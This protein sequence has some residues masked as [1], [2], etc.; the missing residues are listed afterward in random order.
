[1]PPGTT[2]IEKRTIAS[3][4]PTWEASACTQ[5]RECFHWLCAHT[6]ESQND[7]Q[8]P[9]CSHMH[10]LWVTVCHVMVCIDKTCC[11]FLPAVQHLRLCVPARRH[12]PCAGH[13]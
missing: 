13:T 9:Y 1:M 10:G 11:V 7:Q 8:A 4:V 12:P 5:V 3:F 2:A 6:N